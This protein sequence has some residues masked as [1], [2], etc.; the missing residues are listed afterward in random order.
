MV[1]TTKISDILTLKEAGTLIGMGHNSPIKTV[2]STKSVTASD[3][4]SLIVCA[5]IPVDAKLPRVIFA[6]GDAGTTGI[7]DIG[8]YPVTKPASSLVK[9]DAVDQDALGTL[10]DIKTAAVAPTDIRFETK[11]ISTVNS[12][13]WE[14]AG[15]SS[16]P[17]Y[18]HF[19]IVG[20]LT[21]ATTATADMTVI[22]D[23]T[24]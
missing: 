17:S 5:E 23:Y 2:G 1:A 6:S 24:D 13:A 12:K 18:A 19:Y 3:A 10:I 20:T 15:L 11:G 7:I 4:D 14:L 8:L 16:K 9:A 22:V 21:E